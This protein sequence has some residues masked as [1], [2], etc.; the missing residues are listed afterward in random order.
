MNHAE[1]NHAEPNHAEPNHAEPNDAE[2]PVPGRR[3]L[4]AAGGCRSSTTT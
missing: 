3:A 4:L 1:P 2:P